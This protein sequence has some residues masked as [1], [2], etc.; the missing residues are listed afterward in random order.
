MEKK[1]CPKCESELRQSYGKNRSG[2]QRVKCVSCGKTYTLNPKEK[3][4]S[5]EIRCQAMKIHFAGASGRK[6]G[7]V[8]GFSK[9]NVYN[10][11]KQAK[12]NADG[13]DK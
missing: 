1:K 7:Q 3:G 8:M 13:V 2:S 6:V 4:Y 12:K 5:E 9:A 10:W 11:C